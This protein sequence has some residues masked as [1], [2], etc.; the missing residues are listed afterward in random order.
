MDMCRPVRNKSR[1]EN[2]SRLHGAGRGVAEPG[3]TVRAEPRRAI[4]RPY[5]TSSFVM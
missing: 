5:M 2:G 1:R 4:G 3:L